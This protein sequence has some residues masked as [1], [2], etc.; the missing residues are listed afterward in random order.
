MLLV[1]V[2]SYLIQAILQSRFQKYSKIPNDRM[3]T[4]A[5]IARKTTAYI[6]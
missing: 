3:L 4:G 6:M 5:E 2:A 1:M